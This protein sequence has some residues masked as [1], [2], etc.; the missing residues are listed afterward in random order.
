MFRAHAM[1]MT[2]LHICAY[3]RAAHH[4]R[5]LECGPIEKAVYIGRE[6]VADMPPPT[7]VSDAGVDM[8]AACTTTTVLQLVRSVKPHARHPIVH[9]FTLT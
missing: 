3:R 5:S 8:L 7:F 2:G 4:R 6:S 1:S 9:L